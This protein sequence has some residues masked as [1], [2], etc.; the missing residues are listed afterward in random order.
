M[1]ASGDKKGQFHAAHPLKHIENVLAV[2]LLVHAAVDLGDLA[3]EPQAFP[4]LHGHELLI[5]PVEVI[6]EKSYLLID[7]VQGIAFRYSP[8]GGTS[9]LNFSPQEGQ[10]TSTL[11]GSTALI[12][13]YRFCK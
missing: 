5:P 10:A 4:V 1:P 6:P 12:C 13:W 3:A 2:S 9:I 8:K 11:M 7:P